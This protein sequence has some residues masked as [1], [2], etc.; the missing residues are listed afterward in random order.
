V[1]G[2][3]AYFVS[4]GDWRVHD[5]VQ[6]PPGKRSDEG[7]VVT[8]N[9]VTGTTKL[10]YSTSNPGPDDRGAVLELA[11]W[12]GQGVGAIRDIPSAAEL[13]RRLWREC[14]EAA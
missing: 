12:A 6:P 5:V 9:T 4:S 8:T 11:L 2:C 1:F 13:V 10:R 3:S 7:D 14:L